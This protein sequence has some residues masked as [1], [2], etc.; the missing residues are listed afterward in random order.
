MSFDIHSTT[1]MLQAISNYDEPFTFMRDVFFPNML[2]F[3][4]EKALIDIEDGGKKMAPLVAPYVNGSLDKRSGYTT[5]EITTPRIAPFRKL[6]GDDLKKRMPGESLISTKSAA[7]RAQEYLAK[8]LVDLDKQIIYSEEYMATKV[9]L[10][11]PVAI[12]QVDEAGTATG[13]TFG[14]DYGFTNTVAVASAKKWTVETVNPIENIEDWIETKLLQDSSYSP[15]IVVMGPDVA[16]AFLN[17]PF[18]K[19]VVKMRATAGNL[20][21]PTY[22]GNGA[23]FLGT[24]T[25]YGIEIYSY[26]NLV[27]QGSG[28]PTQLIPSGTVIVG[29]SGLGTMHYGA[30]TQLED[31]KGWL[32]Y[33][34][35]RVPLY[36]VDQKNQVEEIKVTSRP[37]PAP[38]DVK[39][40]LVATG[41]C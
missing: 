1:F 16:K 32:T 41:V 34:E 30:V 8:D 23:T 12:P 19:D 28:T 11:S 17:N 3:P 35:K 31:G 22:K 21:E 7:Q 5:K 25:K 33:E 14:I 20:G 2:T 18:V 26:S 27:D 39:S 29:A 4:T 24:F 36:T 9:M 38:K 37:L 40:F 15:N 10:G 6:T 13:L